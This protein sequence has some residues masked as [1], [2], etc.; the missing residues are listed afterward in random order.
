MS[1]PEEFSAV[2]QDASRPTT[3]TTLPSEIR[4]RIY[5]MLCEDAASTVIIDRSP[6]KVIPAVRC[7]FLFGT[8]RS[9]PTDAVDL[10]TLSGWMESFHK[11]EVEICLH[12][13]CRL[14][15][16]EFTPHAAQQLSLRVIKTDRCPD[17]RRAPFPPLV[18]VVPHLITTE[19]R[20][21]NLEALHGRHVWT[22]AH[23]L[24]GPA[25]QNF[26][27]LTLVSLGHFFY[28]SESFIAKRWPL[29]EP[30]MQMVFK[31][32]EEDFL[33]MRL[34]GTQTILRSSETDQIKLKHSVF[35]GAECEDSH[36]GQPI[37]RMSPGMCWSLEE[38]GNGSTIVRHN[39]LEDY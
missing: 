38:S 26:P 20:H 11:P 37:I 8:Y 16:N 1:T 34:Q 3:L 27:K 35:S 21:L 32:M 5:D 10:E 13:V 19:L 28:V 4:Y 36:T 31:D 33:D 39:I 18:R 6:D 2:L 12:Q 24:L 22:K 17:L 30:V 23:E 25:H 7:K 29:E 15:R 9:K 14:L